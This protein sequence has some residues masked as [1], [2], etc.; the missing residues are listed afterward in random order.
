MEP[1]TAHEKAN[2]EKF[3]RWAGHFDRWGF[4]FRYFQKRVLSRLAPPKGSAFLDLGCGTG[5]AVCRVARLLVGQGFFVGVDISEKMIEKAE[6][7]SK[8]LAN[9]H[10]HVA[11][12]EA[13]PFKK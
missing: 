9:V 4:A 6:A 10:F 12:V 7:N 1:F 13:L 11:S 3:D 8:G 5:W 2:R